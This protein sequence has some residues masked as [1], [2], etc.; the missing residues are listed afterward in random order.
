MRAWSLHRCAVVLRQIF[1]E[2]PLGMTLRAHRVATTVYTDVSA[3]KNNPDG[4]RGQAEIGGCV[5]VEDKCVPIAGCPRCACVCACVY[6]LVLSRARAH[7][8]GWVCGWTEPRIV[9]PHP[10]FDHYERTHASSNKP[11]AVGSLTSP[12]PLLPPP[13][14]PPTHGPGRMSLSV[15]AGSPRSTARAAWAWRTTLWWPG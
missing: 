4:S 1:R 13:A 2:G 12:P 9:R 3:Y 15:P 8:S 14:H 10:V 5:R 7:G 6:P 11:M